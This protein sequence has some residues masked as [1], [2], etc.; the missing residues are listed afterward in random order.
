M[1]PNLVL[2]FTREV[3]SSMKPKRVAVYIRVSTGDQNA[4][5]QRNELT[6]YCKFRKWEIVETYSDV[7]SGAKD[8]RPALDR[9]MVDARR[10]KF[11]VVAVWR[12]V[13]ERGLRIPE[14]WATG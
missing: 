13:T 3:Q 5:L 8:K 2:N 14:L 7:M 1:V 11:D 4:D 6:D 9:L 10:G 12:F